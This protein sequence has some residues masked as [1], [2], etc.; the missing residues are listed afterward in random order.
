MYDFAAK[1]NHGNNV[2]NVQQHFKAETK[3]CIPSFLLQQLL[4]FFL[5]FIIKFQI[6]FVVEIQNFIYQLHAQYE[7]NY[8]IENN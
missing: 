6:L 3:F 1:L 2:S 5:L 7:I 8:Y 4:L